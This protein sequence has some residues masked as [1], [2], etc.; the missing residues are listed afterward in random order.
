[1]FGENNC[2]LAA[3]LIHS[4]RTG[5]RN[6]RR[7]EGKKESSLCPLTGL[8]NTYRLNNRYTMYIICTLA[9]PLVSPLWQPLSLANETYI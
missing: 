5:R 4:S 2:G 7:E 8:F 9:T 3:T 6:E 1:M